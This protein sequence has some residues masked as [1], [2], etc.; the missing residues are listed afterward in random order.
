VVIYISSEDIANGDVAKAVRKLA[1]DAAQAIYPRDTGVI[2]RS[3]WMLS[4]APL[5]EQTLLFQ[6]HGIG[7][8]SV[9]Q[10]LAAKLKEDSS[11]RVVGG[12]ALPPP[13]QVQREATREP[14]RQLNPPSDSREEEFD[15]AAFNKAQKLNTQTFLDL[16]PGDP[17]LILVSCVASLRSLFALVVKMSG[18][19]W[20]TEQ[21][22]SMANSGTRTYRLAEALSGRWVER[23]FAELRELLFS[24]DAWAHLPRRCVTMKLQSYAYSLLAHMSGGVCHFFG[25]F[26]CYPYRLF[27]LV[28]ISDAEVGDVATR[29][30]KDP[31]CMYDEF[32]AAFFA[33]FRT[34]DDLMGASC[35]ML[36]YILL[37]IL[38]FDTARIECRHAFIRRLLLASST[39]WS[40]ILQT[41]SADFMLM[42]GRELQRLLDKLRPPSSTSVDSSE[43]VPEV[44]GNANKEKQRRGGGAH[45]AFARFWLLGK[46]FERD[47][48]SAALKEMWTEYRSLKSIGGEA[49]ERFEREGAAG[50][51]SSR[52]VGGSAFGGARVRNSR[53]LES[54]LA[55]PG[56]GLPPSG[57]SASQPSSSSTIIVPRPRDLFSFAE[58]RQEVKVIKETISVGRS[59][60]RDR[61]KA[62][63]QAIVNWT[64][65]NRV[66]SP[67]GLPPVSFATYALRLPTSASPIKPMAFIQMP[68]PLKELVEKI[69]DDAPPQLLNAIDEIWDKIHD[70]INEDN[71]PRVRPKKFA[72][73][74]CYHARMCVCHDSELRLFIKTLVQTLRPIF[75]A[76]TFARQLL[77][78]ASVII[79][80]RSSDQ[81]VANLFFHISWVNLVTWHAQVQR[82]E[83][84]RGSTEDSSRLRQSRHGFVSLER[85]YLHPPSGPSLGM[86]TWYQHMAGNNFSIPWHLQLCELATESAPVD[87]FRPGDINAHILR[88]EIGMLQSFWRAPRPFVPPQPPQT[89]NPWAITSGEVPRPRPV[90]DAGGSRQPHA[91]HPPPV[92]DGEVPIDEP[93]SDIPIDFE[94]GWLAPPSADQI[95]GLESDTE[96]NKI[97]IALVVQLGDPDEFDLHPCGADGNSDVHGDESLADAAAEARL[98]LSLHTL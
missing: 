87:S 47:S 74:L 1:T 43:V 24:T 3:R 25:I 58:I 78:S 72:L 90:A 77:D 98:R 49:W 66:E 63:M 68:L 46:T 53:N 80:V 76:K 48:F 59:E 62:N 32:A 12:W 4:F 41:L 89:K 34:R 26:H 65:G 42:R 6:V 84:I 88:G 13:P 35:R 75:A 82:L 97:L 7:Q 70:S 10:W 31:A 17:L 91:A 71:A 28:L 23:F 22:A 52:V 61:E 8:R 81:E 39:T 20:D 69:L 85:I 38:R 50:T 9:R 2:N 29:L 55:A 14:A 40:A 94:D 86:A 64:L 95:D 56:P 5:T 33:I 83:W 27:L 18:L 57:S 30:S 93:I 36:L 67:N 73:S 79:L 51:I 19:N 16:E 45:R 11:C 37:V 54:A 96:E 21:E 60:S 15:W 92:M 44:V